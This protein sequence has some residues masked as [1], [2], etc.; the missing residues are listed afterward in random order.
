ML[1]W[2]AIAAVVVIGGAL[3]ARLAHQ[4]RNEAAPAP[5]VEDRSAVRQAMEASVREMN[6]RMPM[7]LSPIVRAERVDF[8]NDVA[9]IYVVQS[10]VFEPG[11]EAKAA[12]QKAMKEAY[13]HGDL[14][15][16]LDAKISVEVDFKTPSRTLDDPF[17]KTWV[18]SFAPSQCL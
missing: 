8:V 5:A 13:C 4:R 10:G 1:R 3:A 14:K 7:Q 11:D 6:K 17:G 9:L 16:A 12:F 18:A 2:I 15:Q